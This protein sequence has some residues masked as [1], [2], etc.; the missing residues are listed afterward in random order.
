MPRNVR[1]RRMSLMRPARTFEIRILSPSSEGARGVIQRF[2]EVERPL[3]RGTSR[4]SG[5][6]VPR[7]HIVNFELGDKERRIIRGGALGSWRWNEINS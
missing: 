7:G 2:I 3:A 1:N 4:P 5:N 6:R